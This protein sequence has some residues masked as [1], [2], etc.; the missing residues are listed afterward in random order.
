[1]E[2][3]QYRSRR[4]A[5]GEIRRVEDPPSSGGA[6]P[7]CSTIVENPLQIGPIMQNKPNL[8]DA[9]MNVTSF[10]KRDYDDLAALRLRKNKPNSNPNKP[11]FLNA[12]INVT[13]FF[14]RDYENQPLRKLP[15][16]KPKQTQFQKSL[17]AGRFSAKLRLNSYFVAKASANGNMRA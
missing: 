8:P 13:F 16:N 4:L 1:M 5:C 11:N 14:T 10:G 15:E 9:Q 7:T 17:D 3:R 2:N 12:Q 6:D